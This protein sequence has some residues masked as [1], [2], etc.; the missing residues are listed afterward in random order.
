MRILVIVAVRIVDEAGEPVLGLDPV[1]RIVRTGE[2]IVPDETLQNA[3]PPDQY[4]LFSID[5]IQRI[6]NQG[7]EVRM[8]VTD[9]WRWA[10]ADYVVVRCG[11]RPEITG[12]RTV[13]LR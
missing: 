4:A 3:I 7:R 11:C 13:V 12:P 2:L 6:W 9:G 1:V 10:T 5:D 8:T